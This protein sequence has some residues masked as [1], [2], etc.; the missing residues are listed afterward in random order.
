MKLLST[1]LFLFSFSAFAQFNDG[2]HI[3]TEETCSTGNCLNVNGSIIEII[4]YEDQ[5]GFEVSSLNKKS[6][7][8]DV[9]TN[10]IQACY[11]GDQAQVHQIASMMKGVNEYNYYNGGHMLVTKLATTNLDDEVAITFQ[12]KTDYD[13]NDIFIKNVYIVPCLETK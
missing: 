6:D 1:L 3:E 4:S 12:F 9:F 10:D 2:F 11:F 13:G 7:L 8:I 5:E